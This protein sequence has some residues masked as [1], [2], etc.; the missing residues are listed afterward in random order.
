MVTSDNAL[1]RMI[2][3][4]VPSV[5]SHTHSVFQ[6]RCIAAF[7]A[8]VVLMM[9]TGLHCISPSFNRNINAYRVSTFV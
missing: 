7:R 5:C 8:A 6:T 1:L 3:V 4:D 9:S 2:S